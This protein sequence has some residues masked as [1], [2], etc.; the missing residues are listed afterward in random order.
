MAKNNLIVKSNQV[1]EA[2]Y[3]LTTIEQRLILSAIAQVPKGE[4]V[5]DDVLYPLFTE[6]LIKLG[7]DKKASHK[8][9]KEAVNRL[10]ERSIVLRDGD[11]SDSFRWIQEKAFNGPSMA[12]VRFSKPILPFLSNLKAEFTKYLESDIVGM[13][14]PY[15]IR[16]YELMMQYRSIGKREISL[17]DLRWMFQLQD[18]YPVWADLKTSN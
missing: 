2:S 10:Y 8:E 1:V 4:E 11:E 16:I 7:G 9:F 17:E 12:F 6:D 14:S 18:K 13:S 5:S 15:A 3:T